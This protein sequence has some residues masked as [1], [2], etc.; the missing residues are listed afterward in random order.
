MAKVGV[1]DASDHRFESCCP[2]CLYASI[3]HLVER[4]ASNQKAASSSLA[5]CNHASV[6]QWWSS[7]FVIR[8]LRVQVLSLAFMFL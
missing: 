6:A 1:L 2:D 7:C 5:W 4:L 8:R 3:A